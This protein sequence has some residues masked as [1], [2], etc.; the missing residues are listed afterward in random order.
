[1]AMASVLAAG[2]AQSH[3]SDLVESGTTT[4]SLETEGD[5]Y[6]N[7]TVTGTGA[8]TTTGSGIAVTAGSTISNDVTNEDGGTIE[9]DDV[10]ILVSYSST[11]VGDITNETGGEI[12]ADFAGI[13]ISSYSEVGGDIVNNGQITSDGVEVSVSASAMVSGNVINAPLDIQEGTGIGIMVNGESDITGSLINN[14]DID[15]ASS[16]ILVG[17]TSDVATNIT[18]GSGGDITTGDYGIVVHQTSTVGGDIIN[19]G[20]INGSDMGIVVWT[21]SQVGGDII[22]S[23]VI[24]AE[25]GEDH[26]AVGIDVHTSTITGEINNSGIITADDYSIHVGT[27]ATV[28]G[29]VDNS[30]T[31]TGGLWL[32]G[33]D[34]ID[35]DNSGVLDL[36]DTIDNYISGDFDQDGDGEFAF[37]L[38][39]AANYEA[40]EWILTVAG[41]TT[42]DGLLT[43]TFADGF[44]LN[45]DDTFQFI[46]VSDGGLTGTFA[47]LAED[48]EIGRS[49]GYALLI[50]YDLNDDGDVGAYVNYVPE[51]GSMALMATLLAGVWLS[52]RLR[53]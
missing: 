41:D 53:K 47:G 1:V 33:T 32:R 52:R 5:D 25:G 19:Q 17:S 39:L 40:D 16:G 49:N 45:E 15:A 6:D 34:A 21:N 42:L 35:L 46:D 8:I 36:V 43:V 48:A 27:A 37:E 10:G 13:L 3:A 31:L 4:D 50:T 28:T 20:N 23:G 14:G 22:N 11:V 18:N 2:A 44:E 30:G 7:V 12:E 24:T 26:G 38:D 29:H 9:A 51:P